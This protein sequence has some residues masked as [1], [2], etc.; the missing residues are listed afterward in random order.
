[1]YVYEHT[2]IRKYGT[3]VLC[4]KSNDLHV[5]IDVCNY[6]GT[7][8]TILGMYYNYAQNATYVHCKGL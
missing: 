6:E 5:H 2:Y 7:G 4:K 1:M 8:T 3:Y